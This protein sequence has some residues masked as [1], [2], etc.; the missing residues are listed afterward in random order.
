MCIAAFV[1]ILSIVAAGD[2]GARR[3]LTVVIIGM[4]AGGLILFRQLRKAASSLIASEA[5]AHYA[6]THDHLTQ[7]PNKALFV[8]RLRCVAQNRGG[9]EPDTGYGI[10]CVGLDRFD[11]I[12]EALGLE[13]C[14]S[15]I[16]EVATRLRLAR[17]D[18]DAIAKLGDDVF[19]VLWPGLTAAEAPA[20]VARLIEQLSAPYAASDGRAFVTCSIGV[21]LLAP[22]IDNPMETLRQAQIALSNAKRRGGAHVSLFE[23]SMDRALKDRKA[24]EVELRRALADEAL[25][26]VYQ[27]QVDAKGAIIGV[28]AL[29]RWDSPTRGAVPPSLF[30]PLAEACGLADV[31]GRFALRRAFLDA[32][33]WPGLKVAVNVSAAQVRSGGLID[34]LKSL[35]AEI[36]ADPRGFE[37]EITEGMLLADEADI[38][39]TLNDVRRMGFSLSLDDFGTGY[40]SL[41]YLR[42]FPVDKL[43]IDRSFVAHLGKRPE[44]SAIIKAIVD[45]ADALGLNV[46]AEGVE[47]KDQ[48]LRLTMAGCA[49]F[50]GFYF[51]RPMEAGAIDALLTARARRVA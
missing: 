50:Q 18:Q 27:P 25:T 2:P 41:S 5:R 44:S 9:G 34:T 12:N 32:K 39:Q 40:S 15:V 13:A 42:H 33:A 45:M 26:V 19:A 48:V 24:L 14:H 3:L 49:Q 20:V 36:G 28:E 8:E 37:L 22:E 31:L 17:R 47:T 11:E 46:I 16:G 38:Y 51:S 1:V 43:K 35:I 6:A 30:V 10:V 29:M 23:P 4:A 7:L 21:G